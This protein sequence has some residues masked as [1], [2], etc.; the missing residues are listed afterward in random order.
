MS[1]RWR[2]AGGALLLA[3]SAAPAQAQ[4]VVWHS[5]MPRV[6]VFLDEQ[7]TAASGV[8]TRFL[9]EAGFDVIDPAFART[10]AQRD[11]AARALAG[12]A[13]AATALGRDLGAQVL[14]LGAAPSEAVASP[15]DRSL[16]VATADLSVRALRLD[17][18]HLVSA[19]S[20]SARALDATATGARTQAL[21][22][23][24]EELLYRTR[25]LGDVMTNWEENRWDD[26]SYWADAPPA[27][28]S[29]TAATAPAPTRT[30]PVASLELAILE[31]GV[32]AA[33][34]AGTRGIGIVARP[35]QQAGTQP[36]GPVVASAAGQ[37]GIRGIVSDARAAVM[38]A[39]SPAKVRAPS[40]AERAR[41]GLRTGD[42]IFEAAVP[43]PPGQ[44]TLRV[45][46][47][48]GAVETGQ[49][50]RPRIGKQWAVVIGVSKYADSRI[51]SLRFA[52][53]D[54]RAM[55]DFLRSPAGGSV[56][57]ERI[58]LL[59]NEK[60]TAAAIREALF[61]FLQDAAPEDQVTVYV[62][63][64]GSPDPRRSANLYILPYDTNAD[65][66]AATAFPMWDF[67]T[68]LRRQIAAERVVVIADA[69]H[70]GGAL[71][72]EANPIGGAFAE[73]FNPSRRVTLSAAAANE[74]SLEGEQWG[75]GHG[76]FTFTLL[77]GLKGAADQDGNGAVT[78]SEAA[79]Y[80]ER[81]VPLSTDK[82]QNPQRAGRGDLVLA[83]LGAGS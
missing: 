39:G 42:A 52:D 4:K 33:S 75:G 78:F 54:A 32:L 27:A 25:F 36:Q 50:I 61:V 83:H 31:S 20:A 72:Q 5:D 9:A 7:G 34:D 8:L 58:R 41:Y 71:V 30:T 63:S 12:D 2:L 28:P 76:A 68:A 10:V 13:V 35:T 47:R 67:K 80:V 48:Q 46:A 3:L 59:V 66:V 65:A 57:E 6:M 37:V 1:A 81:R 53:A 69:C 79:Q 45:T 77:Q 82:R 14:I 60:A 29:I 73:L 70:S 55:Y 23:A 17:R 22:K 43:L 15:A 49:L 18:P 74:S 19:A 40:A 44:D 16:Q 38:V 11:Q 24:S 64:H 62:A 51:T 21:R 56:A 26:R